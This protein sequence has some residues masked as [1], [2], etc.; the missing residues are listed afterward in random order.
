[1]GYDISILH[2]VLGCGYRFAINSHRSTFYGIFL[3]LSAMY[4]RHTGQAYIV[5]QRSV[6][7]LARKYVQQF[8]APPSFLA[9]CIIGEMVRCNTSQ[10]ILK[11]IGSRPWITRGDNHRGWVLKRLLFF[12]W[13]VGCRLG[14]FNK[15]HCR[16]NRS[17]PTRKQRYDPW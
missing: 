13:G 12:Q 15:R 17:A 9:V 7:K 5:F 16:V 2:N 8:S 3:G 11:E 6:P 4:K 14:R 1:M 10:A